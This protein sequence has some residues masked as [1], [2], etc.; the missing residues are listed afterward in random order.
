[1]TVLIV[2]ANMLKKVNEE[3]IL[4]FVTPSPFYNQFDRKL[5]QL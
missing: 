2:Q 4:Q 5:L 1:M 3:S